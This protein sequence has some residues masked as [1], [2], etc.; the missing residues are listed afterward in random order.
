MPQGEDWAQL[1]KAALC[2]ADPD[3]CEATGDKA[4]P[5]QCRMAPLLPSSVGL[6]N[7]SQSTTDS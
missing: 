7:L 5:A 1:E 2:R 3:G 6:F 4:A